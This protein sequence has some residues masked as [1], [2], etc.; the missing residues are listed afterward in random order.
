MTT[1]KFALSKYT[2]LTPMLVSFLKAIPT[3]IIFNKNYGLRHPGAIYNLVTADILDY[4]YEIKMDNLPV[5]PKYYD[6]VGR[7]FSNVL[8]EFFKFYDSCYE[9]MLCF[10]NKSSGPAKGE[11]IHVWMKKNGFD[12]GY[13]FHEET[14]APIKELR[15]TYNL[16]KHSS[17]RLIGVTIR[18]A[19]QF[20]YGY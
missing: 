18:N 7:I 9:I 8:Y 16:L 20:T 5:E 6:N 10:C 11:P 17:N 19:K 3:D 13:N 2:G 12:L 1:T 4:I 15:N 14:K